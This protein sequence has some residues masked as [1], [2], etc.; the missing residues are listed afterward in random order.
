MRLAGNDEALAT[1]ER[2]SSHL[3]DNGL[4]VKKVELG[5]GKELHFDPKTEK[6]IDNSVADQMLTREYRAPFIVPAA[7][8]V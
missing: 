6:F 7:G 4:D 8:Q 1:F 2:F 3:A 5:F